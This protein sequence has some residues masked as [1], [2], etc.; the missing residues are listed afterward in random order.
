MKQTRA[1]VDF[2]AKGIS[3]IMSEARKKWKKKATKAY[4]VGRILLSL[5]FL[6]LIPPL[7]PAPRPVS[8]QNSECDSEPIL[9]E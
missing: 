4:D 7:N 2:G 5:L 6:P 1:R 3:D 8:P 9:Q